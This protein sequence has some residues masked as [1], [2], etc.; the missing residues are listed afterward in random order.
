MDQT[1]VL[2]GKIKVIDLVGRG[3]VNSVNFAEVCLRLC[4]ERQGKEMKHK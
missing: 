4:D 2:D 3:T 1:S